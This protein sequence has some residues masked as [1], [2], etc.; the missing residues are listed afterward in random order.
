MPER[1]GEPS[2]FKHVI[3]IIKENRTYDQILGDM[4][5]GNGDPELCTFGEKITPNQHKISREFILLDN[6]YCSGVVSAD[7]HQW[8]DSSIVNE[9]V[10]RQLSSDF[11]RSYSGGKDAAGS[12]A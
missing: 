9:Y 1:V 12:D 4:P 8:T 2:V 7:G 11:P 5:E 6:T 3:Y 10:E